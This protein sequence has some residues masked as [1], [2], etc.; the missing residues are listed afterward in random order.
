MAEAFARSRGAEAFSAGTEPARRVHPLAV[1]VMAEKDIDLSATE[2]KP[3]A[4]FLDQPFDAVITVCGDAEERCPA[5][6]GTVHREHWP[7]PDP[8]KAAGNETERLDFF[9]RVRDELEN[10]VKSL[11][12]TGR[13]E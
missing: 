7:L 3:L 12:E 11:L 6:P 1:Q 10:R 5:F 4:P 13:F 9:R 8:A 2:P